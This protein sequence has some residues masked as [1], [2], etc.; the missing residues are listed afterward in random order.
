M[1][2]SLMLVLSIFCL[3]GCDEAAPS[4]G[5][6]SGPM[7]DAGSARD[8][9]SASDSG[10]LTP[11][12]GPADAGSTTDSGPTPD[13]GPTPLHCRGAEP[14]IA[15][16]DPTGGGVSVFNPSDG[17]LEGFTLMVGA[18]TAS[19]EDAVP[20]HGTV[21]VAWPE[22][23]PGDG[24]NGELGISPTSDGGMVDYVCWGEGI[25]DSSLPGIAQIQY[26]W[27]G[28]CSNVM[29]GDSYTLSRRAD[30]NG[31][32]PED[33]EFGVGSNLFCE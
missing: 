10:P 11:D 1:T 24:T 5:T 12:A 15:A 23:F 33:Y 20:S 8:A 26:I 27:N 31:T 14:I 9:G 19:F 3:L 7:A 28:G 18:E 17:L 25:A 16:I 21:T 32:Y 29:F 4:T 30:T 2:R 6:D 13:A 22:S